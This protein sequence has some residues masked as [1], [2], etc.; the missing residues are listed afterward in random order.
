M[1]VLKHTC[2]YVKRVA[3]KELK[4]LGG[5]LALEYRGVWGGKL[6]WHKDVPHWM[7]RSPHTHTHQPNG[8]VT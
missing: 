6:T 5:A 4:E 8:Q 2:V 3:M 1:Y 7:A